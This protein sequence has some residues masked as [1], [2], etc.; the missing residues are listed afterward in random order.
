MTQEAG[1]TA[2]HSP[3]YRYENKFREELKK[4]VQVTQLKWWMDLELFLITMKFWLTD[5]VDLKL[6]ME[7]EIEKVQILL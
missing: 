6:I 2:P 3:F 4:F 1:I 7:E 5:Q